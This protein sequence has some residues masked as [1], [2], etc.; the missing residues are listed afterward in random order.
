MNA[1]RRRDGVHGMHKRIHE[2]PRRVALDVHEGVGA[3]SNAERRRRGV[4]ECEGGAF[5][6]THTHFA[7]PARVERSVA[8]ASRRRGI[9]GERCWRTTPMSSR[10]QIVVD[11]FFAA[12]R[13]SGAHSRPAEAERRAHRPRRAAA[14]VHPSVAPTRAR[15]YARSAA[16]ARA[17]ERSGVAGTQRVLAQRHA[18]LCAKSNSRTAVGGAAARRRLRARQSGRRVVERAVVRDDLFGPWPHLEQGAGRPPRAPPV[19]PSPPRAP[20]RS[21]VRQHGKGA[22]RGGLARR[23]GA[24]WAAPRDGG[25]RE[26]SFIID[27][28]RRADVLA[29]I[30]ALAGMILARRALRR[31]AYRRSCSL[32]SPPPCDFA[33]LSVSGGP[34]PPAATRGSLEEAVEASHAL[35]A[36]G[37]PAR[38]ASSAIAASSPSARRPSRAPR[39]V[40]AIPSAALPT[41]SATRAPRRRPT[42]RSR[43]TCRPR[44]TRLRVGARDCRA[45]G[46]D[47]IRAARTRRRARRRARATSAARSPPP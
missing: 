6:A 3:P 37:R 19:P 28:A 16:Y 33:V 44:S 15:R 8:R 7:T 34:A 35:P 14:R 45:G 2:P 32:S 26:V 18:A 10:N 4:P 12:W 27:A 25:L 20:L 22:P 24:P 31:A 39:A 17:D 41:S 11:A 46:V 42:P 36:S 30:L 38:R 9:L 47:D 43:N 5:A 21:A 40:V 13:H 29:G 23:R 1:D